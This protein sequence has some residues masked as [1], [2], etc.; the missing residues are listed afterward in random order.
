MIKAKQLASVNAVAA[1]DNS[2]GVV[3]EVN[4]TDGGDVKATRVAKINLGVDV[5]C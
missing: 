1:C 5:F 3:D 4:S 2:G